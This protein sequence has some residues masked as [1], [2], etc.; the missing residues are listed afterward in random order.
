MSERRTLSQIYDGDLAL[1]DRTV[2]HLRTK[3]MIP[4]PLHGVAYA[5]GVIVCGRVFCT[6]CREWK[7]VDADA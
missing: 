4:H 2:A 6:P 3:V 7:R 5:D 1:R